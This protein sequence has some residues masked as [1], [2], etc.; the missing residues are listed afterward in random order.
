MPRLFQKAKASGHKILIVDD[1]DEVLES[2]RLLLEKDGHE[3]QTAN[4]GPDGIE[5]VKGWQPHLLILDYFMPGM[6]GEEVVTAIRPFN[7]ET[8]ILLQTGY[9]SE[10]P[11][12]QML[13]ALDIQGYHDKSEGPEKLLIWVD[14]SLKAYRQIATINKSKRGLRHIL[15]AIP[16]MY[17]LQTLEDLLKGVLEQMEGLLGGHHS[18]VA[19]LPEAFNRTGDSP[20]DSLAA[21]LTNEE[22][23]EIVAGTGRFANFDSLEE[24]DRDLLK[25]M[26]EMMGMDLVTEEGTRTFIPL[27]V[28]SKSLGIIYF[29]RK[30]DDDYDIELLKIFAMQ[31]SQALENRR[32]FGMATEDDLTK[33]FLKNFFFKRME[34]EIQEA[35]RYEYPISLCII[36]VDKFKGINDTHG[37]IVGDI[38]LK[39]VSGVIRTSVRSH[40]FV[41]RFGG[42]EFVIALPHTDRKIATDVVERLRKKVEALVLGEVDPSVRVTLSCGVATLQDFPPDRTVL[43][44]P[45]L[46]RMVERMLEAA[47]QALYLSKQQGRNAVNTA[48]S[49]SVGQLTEEREVAR[50]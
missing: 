15:D 46:T 26:R 2:T 47:D 28:G 19:A 30:N 31:A 32:L 23:L 14:A 4:N 12:R 18:F 20:A 17:N 1:T 27:R 29:D 35:C 16:E 44:R 25:K 11:P 48:A 45:T 43:K 36:D 49:L 6:T 42:D 34:D 33:T 22:D 37:H 38:V 39:E 21:T 24:I 10:K 9:A 41:G 5:K 13:H 7:K 50:S 8:Q 3:I 40:D